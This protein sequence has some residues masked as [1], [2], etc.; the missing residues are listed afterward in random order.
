MAFI[1]LMS[2]LLRRRSKEEFVDEPK[3]EPHEFQTSG[4]PASTGP[5]ISA[6]QAP[7]P[8]AQAAE[9]PAPAANGPDVPLTG[10]PT[11]WTMEQWT[12]YGQQ[13][14]DRLEGQA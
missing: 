5:P 1:I 13:Y 12:H 14:L 2:V 3:I 9:A 7:T 4:P 8:E 6:Q 10:L 11:G